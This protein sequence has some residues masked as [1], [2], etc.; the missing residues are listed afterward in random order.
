MRADLEGA[1][2]CD[3]KNRVLDHAPALTAAAGAAAELDCLVALARGARQLNLHRPQ[4]TRDNV[5]R[6]KNG[7][8]LSTCECTH[9]LR[10]TYACCVHTGRHLLQEQRVDVFVP[11]DTHVGATEGRINIVTGPNFS[12]KSVY[13]VRLSERMSFVHHILTS[14]AC[15]FPCWSAPLQKQVALIVFL[16]HTG[17]FVPAD[18]AIIGLTD[19]IFTRITSSDSLDAA[20]AQ[21]SFMCDTHQVCSLLLPVLRCVYMR[22]CVWPLAECSALHAC[23]ARWR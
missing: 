1:L 4:L 15:P 7:A 6:I 16:A 9:A 10:I 19:R 13:L 18:E 21:S 11:N 2:L 12:G 22:A 20:V 8:S 14:M 3:L 5:L 17:S 23:A